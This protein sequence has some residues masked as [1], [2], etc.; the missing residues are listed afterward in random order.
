MTF[1]LP[2]TPHTSVVRKDVD[3][4]IFSGILIERIEVFDTNYEVVLKR[5]QAF[6]FV[7]LIL[8]CVGNTAR[9]LG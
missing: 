7:K 5:L 3:K 4:N 6:F 1:S 8:N 2:K 9:L